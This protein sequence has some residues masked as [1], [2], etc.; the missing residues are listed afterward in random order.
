VSRWV[1]GY[2]YWGAFW[3]LLAF[4]IPELLAVYKVAPWP[5]FSATTVHATKTYPWVAY[6]VLGVLIGLGTHF[7]AGRHLWPSLV[8]GVVVSV[9][10]HLLNKAWP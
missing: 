8:F 4:L 7:L 3:L 2:I 1:Y 10:A 5:T 6:A 9:G